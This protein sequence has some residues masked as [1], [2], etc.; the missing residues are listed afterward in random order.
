[1]NE[2]NV[3]DMKNVKQ[4]EVDLFN[5]FKAS[6]FTD[7]HS[8]Q[9]LHASLAPILHSAAQKASFNSNIPLSAHQGYASQAFLDAL[10]TYDPTAGAALQT[11]IFASVHQ[12]VKR[13]NYKYQ[14]IGS[15]PEPRA[16][17]VGLYL[18]ELETF[19]A[20]NG[21]EPT[22]MELSKILGMPI[23][24]VRNLKKEVVKDLQID[25]NLEETAFHEGSRAAEKLQYLRHDLSGDELRVY[26]AIFGHDNTQGHI[27]KNGKIDFDTI[28][29]E[30]GMSPTRVR[31]V[32]SNIKKKF[33]KFAR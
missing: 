8:F 14:N 27:K 28:A 7:K 22:E 17:R 10:R 29:R 1:M 13:L 11:H 2:N 15:M 21:R 12:K 26:D 19:K 31:T 4:R 25:E 18:N 20:T 9:E 3:K 30:L 33:D 5:Q 23:A 32:A 16:Q 6:G 24:D